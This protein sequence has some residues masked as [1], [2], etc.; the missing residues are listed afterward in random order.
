MF[1]RVYEQSNIDIFF[2]DWEH[3]KELLI[4]NANE[5]RTEKYRGAWRL[6]SVAN[7]FNRLIN[8]RYI[9]LPFCFFWLVFAWW[10]LDWGKYTNHIPSKTLSVNSP[11]NY[12]LMH[13]LGSFVLILCGLGHYMFWHIIQFAVPLKKD[14]F[15]D[16]CCVANT[17][18]FILDQSLHG[19]YIHGQSPAGKSDTNLDE[20][21]RFLDEEGTGKAKGRGLV[22]KDPD[23]LQTY[24]LFISYKMRISYD[25]IFGLQTETMI[26]SAQSRDKLHNQSRLI[27]Y[28]LESL[29]L[30]K[31]YQR[32]YNMIKF[33]NSNLI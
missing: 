9:S 17:S 31:L 14:D 16:L 29:T 12:I 4:K 32:V 18:V 21:L 13:F 27:Y 30:S 26:N 11:D 25:G 33:T 10:Y 23:N 5:L 2:I 20:L 1:N 6:V 8:E 24:E 19:Y 15:I 28:N 22:D 7:Q 3:D